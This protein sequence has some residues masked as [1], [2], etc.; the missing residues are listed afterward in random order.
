MF[1]GDSAEMC[2]GKISASVDGGPSGGSRCADPGARTPIGASGNC[3]VYHFSGSSIC[4][5]IYSLPNPSSL[6]LSTGS[7]KV[8]PLLTNKRGAL[9][10]F[11][12]IRLLENTLMRSLESPAKKRKIIT[13]EF[14]FEN[15]PTFWTGN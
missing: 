13:K 2:A 11:R 15:L 1:E 6:S 10:S 14:N 4:I 7:C 9:I 12:Q 8:L 5:A 3:T